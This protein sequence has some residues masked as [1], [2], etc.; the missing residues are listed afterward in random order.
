[1][2]PRPCGFSMSSM[3]DRMAA[4]LDHALW[5]AAKR[6]DDELVEFLLR[7]GADARVAI[8]GMTPLMLAVDGGKILLVRTLL[9]VDG[10]D[11]NEIAT[12]TYTCEGCESETVA[13]SA[14]IRAAAL[15][16]TEIAKLLI[17]RGADVNALT[18]SG[19]APLLEAAE[20]GHEDTVKLLIEEGADVQRFGTEAL[21]LARDGR[22]IEIGVRLRHAGAPDQPIDFRKP[23]ILRPTMAVNL[24][25]RRPCITPGCEKPTPAR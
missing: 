25:G 19:N 20:E 3:R 12:F 24:R 21:Q 11:V 5:I 15:G 4:T 6:G 22:H 1:M 16:R 7:N 10:G 9:G 8:D 13:Y 2:E 17:D 23:S 14:L 18:K